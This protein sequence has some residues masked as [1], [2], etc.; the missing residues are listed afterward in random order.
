MFFILK[1]LN[2]NQNDVT[3]PEWI[4]NRLCGLNLLNNMIL[5]RLKNETE[6]KILQD[7][8][9][10]LDDL[11]L[12]DLIAFLSEQLDFGGA[13]EK[14]YE[15][16]PMSSFEFYATLLSAVE[17]IQNIQQVKN[18]VQKKFQIKKI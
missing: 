3:N 5:F 14:V 11:T 17:G 4:R 7:S 2:V 9:C 15:N 1:M 10:S 16:T 13:K 18:S 8:L 6:Y 12:T